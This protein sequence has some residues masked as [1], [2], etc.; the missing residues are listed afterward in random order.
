MNHPVKNGIY[1]LSY[2]EDILSID[3]KYNLIQ[4]GFTDKKL[5]LLRIML[6][7]K[8]LCYENLFNLNDIII[9]T[10]MDEIY[11]FYMLLNGIKNKKYNI[12]FNRD[13]TVLLFEYSNQNI[14]FYDFIS[15]K[16][17]LSL[18][19]NVN[20]KII[21]LNEANIKLLSE[22]NSKNKTVLRLNAESIFLS[23][24]KITNKIFKDFCLIKINF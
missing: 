14:L 9:K 17:D 24:R 10:R 19:Y 8:I 23:G 5:I 1:L 21:I 6:I 4:L 22:F 3:N 12:T 15:I 16:M 13:K 7:N 20:E 18:K 2:H 11:I